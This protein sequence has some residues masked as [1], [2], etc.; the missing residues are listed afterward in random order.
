MLESPQLPPGPLVSIRRLQA[1]SLSP[2]KKRCTRT[3]RPA[4]ASSTAALAEGA[5][6]LSRVPKSKWENM[7][8]LEEIK[9][10][11]KPAGQNFNA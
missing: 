9:E 2:R 1:S 4:Q 3:R 7:L 10:R 5:L 8:R 6:T 11:N